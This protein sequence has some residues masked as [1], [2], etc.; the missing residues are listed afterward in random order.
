M[1]CK[2]SLL[3]TLTLASG[4]VHAGRR[5]PSGVKV[6]PAKIIRETD[7]TSARTEDVIARIE[8]QQ[9]ALSESP[10]EA[11]P[12]TTPAAKPAP[13]PAVRQPAAS[14][15]PADKSESRE[16]TVDYLLSLLDKSER[17]PAEEEAYRRLLGLGGP[18]ENPSGPVESLL[19]EA[20]EAAER[21]D[22]ET[23]QAKA[24]QALTLLRRLTD[25]SIDRLFFAREVRNYGNADVVEVTRFSPGEV[26]LVVADISNF[27]C[28]E[29]PGADPPELYTT[30]MTYRLA[31]YDTRGALHWQ[32]SE[33]PFEYQ[34]STCISS[35]FLPKKFRLPAGLKPGEYVVKAEL[36]D[37]LAGRQ[38][39]AAVDF[40][41]R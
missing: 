4:C 11:Q 28:E 31:I 18:E 22:D 7:E 10:E 34:A 35:M 21:G 33:G 13:Q 2:C 27:A 26:V 29:V 17:T 32:H 23:A 41:V 15:A 1:K 14:A 37:H 39:E 3:L 12:E 16:L 25:P 5:Y 36:V 20:R 30:R 8:D 38:T 19:V 9:A 40:T 24:S 6:T